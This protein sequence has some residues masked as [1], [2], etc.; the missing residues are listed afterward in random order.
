MWPDLAY[1]RAH[2]HLGTPLIENPI[3]AARIE[4]VYRD[5][6]NRARWGSFWRVPW[7]KVHQLTIDIRKPY[8]EIPGK[9]TYSGRTYD[10]QYITAFINTHNLP[11][12][13]T[14]AFLT[15]ALRNR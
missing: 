9:G 11:C 6:T 12:N 13:S 7:P 4:M 10:E 8:T 3:S 5:V 15:P 1:R 14:K 2:D